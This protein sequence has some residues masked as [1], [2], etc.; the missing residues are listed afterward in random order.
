MGNDSIRLEDDGLPHDGVSQ[1]PA[2]DEHLRTYARADAEL[3][4]FRAPILLERENPHQRLFIAGFDGTENDVF[5]DPLH[6]T[7]IG[8]LE[9]HFQQSRQAI[10]SR[11]HWQYKTGPG[12]QEFA[13][14]AFLDSVR[15]F[16]YQDRLERMYGDVVKQANRW[17]VLDPGV[18]IR[19]LSTGFSRGGS[20]AA[21]FTNLL[22]ERGIPDTSTAFDI[23]YHD[24][25]SGIGYK[26][27]LVRPGEILQAVALYDPVATGVPMDFNRR[28]PSS[29][30]S[31][32][33]ISAALEERKSF[34][35]DLII[36]EGL[37]ADGRFL[38]VF[39]AGAH[40]DVGGGY[41][42][43]GLSRRNFNLMSDYVNALSEDPFLRKVWVPDDP[44]LVV[45]HRS[46]EGNA[47]FRVHRMLAPADRSD[48][49]GRNERQVPKDA[50]D[51][52][53]LPHR[54]LPAEAEHQARVQ[55]HEI[56]MRPVP[57]Q[58]GPH[59][60]IALA[61]DVRAANVLREQR[62]AHGSQLAYKGLG[63]LGAAAAVYEGVETG[64]ALKDLLQHDNATGAE[65]RMVHFGGQSAGGWAG[66]VAGVKIGVVA[67][68]ESGP[69]MLVTGLVGGAVGAYAGDKLAAW[70][71]QRRIYTQEDRYG[72]TFH[73]DPDRPERG[74]IWTGV[75][76]KTDAAT[77]V[78]VVENRDFRAVGETAL[79]L[80]YKATSKSV[81]LVLGNP[82]TP[83]DPFTQPV[84]S[85]EPVGQG[86]TPWTRD[87]QTG[88]WMRTVTDAFAE[89]G[90]SA[91]HEERA[92]PARAAELDRQAAVVMRENIANSPVAIAAKFERAYF[93]NGWDRPEQAIPGAVAAELAHPEVRLASDGEKYRQREDGE[94]T[95]DGWF[96]ERLAEGNVRLE[97]SASQ[98]A[99]IAA[100][101]EH[102]QSLAVVP[103]APQPS[104]D[105][106]AM[107]R[108]AVQTMYAG[109]KVGVTPD[110]LQA[111]IDAVKENNAHAGVV[112]PYTVELQANA[113]GRI[114]RDSPIA[115]LQGGLDANGEMRPALSVV[116]VTTTQ[117]LARAYAHLESSSPVPDVPVHRITQAT[118]EERDAH[119]QAQRE[120]NRHGLSQPEAVRVAEVATVRVAGRRGDD[121]A[122]HEPVDEG[123][124]Q[125]KR[126]ETTI[127]E[128]PPVPMSSLPHQDAP[129]R[130]DPTM[131]EE[132]SSQRLPSS[133]PLAEASTRAPEAAPVLSPEPEPR[134]PMASTAPR[135]DTSAPDD[136]LRP[137][138]RGDQVELLQFRL[139][140]QGYRGP[141]GEPLPQNG[142]YGPETEHAVRQFQTA[143]DLPAT[144]I[145]DQDTQSAVARAPSP[146][147]ATADRAEPINT[148][149]PEP[150]REA[151]ERAVLP[152]AHEV[153]AT[154]REMRQPEP[155]V[156]PS[157]TAPKLVAG[158]RRPDR[159]DERDVV[160]P[161]REARATPGMTASTHPAHGLY[162]QSQHA[163]E[164]ASA[165]PGM[166]G[167]GEREREALGAAAVAQAVSTP[168][169]NFTGV[170]HVVPGNKIDPQT[171]RPETVFLVQ[172]ALD[173]PGHRR[174]AV[175]VEQALSQ[176]VEQS[177]S[178]AQAAMQ[179]RQQG[180]EQDMARM[181]AQG[182]D[183]A[184]G[185]AIR[186]GAR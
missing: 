18:D 94:W 98:P 31:G 72:R 171:G 17:C 102:T 182:F 173:D 13:P 56:A 39:V 174:I 128:V 172:G 126:A 28:L 101:T 178:V 147:R 117:D 88:A 108:E 121:G 43:D 70:D 168:G 138:A 58:A 68:V 146:Q 85:G 1:Y 78:P 134:A 71:D 89:R 103:R 38:N 69:G 7:N 100:L 166:A 93:E 19:V 116:G 74:W 119:T 152:P 66:A 141:A 15:G 11:I 143:H 167:L 151:F 10:D 96:G 160:E 122:A 95:R 26:N 92:E 76:V 87:A 180:Q 27:Y 81:E 132:R 61:E 4:R 59:E 185:P 44:G 127:P 158:R 115:T 32:F 21:G 33:Q 133:G 176:S 99:L 63:A 57:E 165:A 2:T 14:E 46:T 97:L 157:S 52:P 67:G 142:Q 170:D 37:S 54:P 123:V 130:T 150:T 105:P 140:R 86:S 16:S 64:F 40:S 110:Q 41:L 129:D 181:Q 120:A 153:A 45:V 73:Y 8:R 51:A 107:L 20:Q 124:Q 155:D 175:N 114:A 109:A 106:D 49:T 48:D 118:P 163:M 55:P 156:L 3:A 77:G 164:K 22:H 65:S 9:L 83:R 60:T 149:A 179:T 113:Q 79:E 90:L 42:R 80:N 137:G 35:A 131:Q 162:L 25:R 91:T 125:T 159:D 36:P 23:H 184:Q 104:N 154:A 144:G 12:T 177:S 5:K 47:A 24:G 145:A 34:P 139:D 62:L 29:V 53:P 82:P 112:W 183:E 186:M 136:A 84:A 6:A 169:W 135:V 148:A 75:E 30:V 50:E 111:S 161:E